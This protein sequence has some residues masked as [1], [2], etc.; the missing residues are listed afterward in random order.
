MEKPKTSWN[1]FTARK[2]L[3]VKSWCDRH[4]IKTYKQL[5]TK[6]VSIEIE[7]PPKNEVSFLPHKPVKIKHETTAAIQDIFEA[8]IEDIPRVEEVLTIKEPELPMEDKPKKSRRKKSKDTKI[9]NE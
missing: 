7:P 2:K 5:V 9:D 3:D 8:D 4:S 1:T 6:C